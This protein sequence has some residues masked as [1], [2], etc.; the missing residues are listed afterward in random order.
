M[1]QLTAMKVFQRVAE[2]GSFTQAADALD[3]SRAMVSTQVAALE[4]RYGVRLFNRTTRRVALTSEGSRYLEHCRRVFAELQAAE[5]ELSGARERPRGHL[6]VDVP[7]AFGRGLLVEALPDFLV[8]Y[9]ELEIDVQVNDRYVDLVAAQ[10]DVALRGGTI[11][12]PNLVVR[13]AVGSRWIT[14]AA[15]SYLDQHGWP[16]TPDDLARHALIGG[17]VPPAPGGRPWLFCEGERTRSLDLRF[18]ITSDS[19]EMNLNAAI[20]GAGIIQ[21]LDL[22]AARALEEGRLVPL[23]PGT[24]VRGPPL[25]VVYPSSGQRLAKVRAFADFTIELLRQWQR[26]VERV[27]GLPNPG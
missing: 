20:Q 27:P 16:R 5:E 1:D 11:T 8:R 12:D 7:G 15:P 3:L 26:R 2:T 18:R 21:S 10:V 24:S 19:P 25:S 13:H 9:P 22:L 6:R 14:C 17:R 23:L 4:K